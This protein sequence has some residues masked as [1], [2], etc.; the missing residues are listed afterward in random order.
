M[1]TTTPL[2]IVSADSVKITNEAEVLSR[3]NWFEHKLQQLH[4]SY[5]KVAGKYKLIDETSFIILVESEEQEQTV[6]RLARAFNQE[7]VLFVDSN[8]YAALFDADGNYLKNAGRMTE[9]SEEQAKDLPS[10][11]VVD[12]HYYAATAS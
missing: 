6:F 12:G 10:Y 2:M 1:N 5:R 4:L 3:R 9:V 7:T 8:S 11:T